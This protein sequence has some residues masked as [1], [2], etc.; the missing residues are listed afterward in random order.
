MI[1]LPEI[2]EENE[3]K[4]Y[5][6]TYPRMR[7]ML[8]CVGGSAGFESVIRYCS[9]GGQL[10]DGKVKNLLVGDISVLKVI[11]DEIGVV[12]DDNV[13]TKFEIS[14]QESLVKNGHRR[15]VLQFVLTAI[16]AIFSPQIKEE[17][18]LNM[19]TTFQSR[20]IR[21]SRCLCII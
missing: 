9:T 18:V 14:A 7:D 5:E 1:R 2:S 15:L 8:L 16:G 3:I 17:L 11:I 19:I 20:N 4:F 12:G 13:R 21:T 10:D 6:D